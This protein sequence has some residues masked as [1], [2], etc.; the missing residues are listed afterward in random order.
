MK[1]RVNFPIRDWAV[2]FYTSYTAVTNIFITRSY[3]LHDFLFV[4]MMKTVPSRQ[5]NQTSLP[6]CFANYPNCRMVI[7]CTE[8]RIAIPSKMNEQNMSY[9]SYKSCNTFKALIGAAP[10]GTITF[11]SPLYPGSHSDK[12]ITLHCRLWCTKY[13]WD[14]RFYY[15]W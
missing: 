10:N 5:K 9:S 1:L 13:I 4:R 12:E 15:G 14:R 6:E 3:A 8:V 2:R 7:D 11:A